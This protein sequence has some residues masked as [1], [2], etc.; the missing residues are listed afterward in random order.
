MPVAAV[1]A[2]DFIRRSLSEIW[3]GKSPGR[4]AGHCSSEILVH[5]PD[6]STRRGSGD[7]AAGIAAWLSALPDSQL[8]I[9]RVIPCEDGSHVRASV[10]ASLV[11]HHTG[12]GVYGP[13]TQ[14]RVVLP[15]IMHARLRG[16]RYV[17]LRVEYDEVDLIHQLGLDLQS[18]LSRRLD[19]VELFGEDL[20]LGGPT[21][22]DHPLAPAEEEGRSLQGE[23]LV[24][25]AVAA[26]WNGRL[27]GEISRFYAE[28]YRAWINGRQLFGVE[29]LRREVLALLA[30]L[31]DLQI[32]LD[33]AFGREESDG[34]HISTRWTLLGVNTGA[35]R[36]GAPTNRAVRLSG[37][38]NHH[39]VGGR[40]HAGWTAYNEL[41]LLR[42]LT[43][44][45]EAVSVSVADE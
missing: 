36:Y 40:L 34:Y 15:V 38:T 13:A 43:P 16:E 10:Q 5:L 30:T 21:W 17:E 6:G 20:E 14:Q 2:E 28:R 25:T 12:Q 19:G 1:T 26:V 9:E 32:H 39:I 41:T 35:G 45:A 29:E 7:V 42:Q 33:D 11:G 4:A 44:R 8:F 31:P 24:R 3:D 22:G 23:E 27:Q 37:I 18:V